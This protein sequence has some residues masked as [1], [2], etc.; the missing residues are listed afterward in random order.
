LSHDERPSGRRHGLFPLILALAATTPALASDPVV[1]QKDRAFNIKEV[2]V[3]PGGTV[4]FD[5]NDDFVHQI[6]VQSPSFSYESD[7]QPPSHALNVTF[8]TK[9]TFDVQCRIHPKMHLRVDVR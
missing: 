6:F 5:N 2:Q 9:G 3:Q 7:E 8:P 1:I 4:H